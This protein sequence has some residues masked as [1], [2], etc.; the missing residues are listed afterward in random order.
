MPKS[1]RDELRKHT[2]VPNNDYEPILKALREIVESKRKQGIT[3]HDGRQNSELSAYS[4][5]DNQ[6]VGYN[7]AISEILKE[8][9]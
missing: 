5:T 8:L 7:L 6:K 1:V 3:F 2:N 9:V 4:P